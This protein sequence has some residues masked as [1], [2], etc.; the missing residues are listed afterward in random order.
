MEAPSTI[1]Q[2]RQKVMLVLFVLMIPPVFL[3]SFGN[4]HSLIQHQKEINQISSSISSES[5]WVSSTEIEDD[6]DYNKSE[7]KDEDSVSDDRN[8]TVTRTPLL[9]IG[10]DD[11]AAIKAY[12]DCTKQ[13]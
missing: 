6:D 10:Q 7:S 13:G 11:N 8:S 12:W 1:F 3:V 9:P 5:S 4:M 2:H